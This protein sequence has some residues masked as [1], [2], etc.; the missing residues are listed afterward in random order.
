MGP[1]LTAKAKFA[2]EQP[3]SS[4]V[5]LTPIQAELSTNQAA[6]VHAAANRS[7]SSSGRLPLAIGSYAVWRQRACLRL[8][9]ILVVRMSC[10][11]R[12]SIEG[13]AR[14]VD[15]AIVMN[16]HPALSDE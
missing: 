2:E 14:R 4:A 13:L 11:V 5:T 6:C 16:E 8:P 15:D 1:N 10:Q 9:R 3:A 7:T 12:H